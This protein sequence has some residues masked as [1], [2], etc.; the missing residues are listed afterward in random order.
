MSDIRNR[1]LAIGTTPSNTK[2]SVRDRLLSI[3]GESAALSEQQVNNA[4]QKTFSQSGSKP[5]LVDQATKPRY[6]EKELPGVYNNTARKLDR[7]NNR[8]NSVR[9]ELTSRLAEEAA[10]GQPILDPL[11]EKLKGLERQQAALEAQREKEK[12]EA[13][14][15]KQK[16][17]IDATG[18]STLLPD[19]QRLAELENQVKAYQGM[20]SMDG[21]VPEVDQAVSEYLAL[22]QKLKDQYGKDLNNWKAYASRVGNREM[23]EQLKANTTAD[24]KNNWFG[25][26]LARAPINAASGVGFV[27]ANIQKA[28]RWLTGS[29]APIDYNTPAMQLSQMSNAITKG[30]TERIEEDTAGKWGSDTAVG[31][32]YS[33]LYNLGVSMG[34][35]VIGMATGTSLLMAGAAATN[36]MVE[37][38]ERGATDNQALLFGL[39]AGAMEGVMEKLSIDSLFNMKDPKTAK[40]LALNVLKQGGVEA[41][42]EVATNVANTVADAIIMGDKN[43]LTTAINDYIEQGY[44]P[45][46]AEKKAMKDWGNGLVMDAIGGLIS[47]GTFEAVKGGTGYIS[48]RANTSQ[49]QNPVDAAIQNTL[50][51]NMPRS[52]RTKRDPLRI[53]QQGESTSATMKQSQVDAAIQ[54]TLGQNKIA[55]VAEAKEESASV[56]AV[57]AAGIGFDPYSHASNTY[58]A[59]EPGENP[60]RVV[61]VP[62]SMDGETNVMQTVRTIMEADVT[63]DAA[64][65]VLENEIV[66][67]SFS[68]MPITDQ[69]AAGRAESTIKRVGYD[70]ALADWRAEVRAGRVSKDSVAIGETLYNAA[71]SAGDT[72]SAVKIAIDLSTQV[73][74]AAQALQA[75]RMLK[76]M[77]PAAQLY[78]VKQSVDNLQKQLQ[79]QYGDRAP[80]LV[81]DETLAANFL[82]AKTDAER[83]A[84]EEA[85]YKDIA[86]QIP[87][88]FSDKWNAWRYLSMLGNP[89]THIRN[90]IGNA[91]FAPVRGVKN[92]VGGLMEAIAQRAGIIDKSQRTKSVGFNWSKK[93]RDLLKAAKADYINAEGQIQSGD[94]Y[95]SA[96]DIIEKNRRIFDIA[97]LET[98]RRGNSAAL[99]VEDKWFSKGA[100]ASSLAGY[101]NARGYTAEDFTGNGMTEQQKD[102]ARSYAILEAQKATYRDLNALSELVTSMKFKNP[103]NS[104]TKSGELAK[105]AANTVVEGVLPFKKTPANILARAVE[106]SPAGLIGT[107]GKRVLNSSGGALSNSNVSF[108]KRFGDGMKR[109]TGGEYTATEFMDD[110]SAGL[111][112]SGLF[113]LGYFL[114]QSDLLVGGSPEDEDQF[115][116]ENRQPYALEV[117]GTSVTL[118]WLAPEAL[119]VFMG[120]ELCKAI[121]AVNG[122]AFSM[123]TMKSFFRGVTGPLLEMSMLSGL[124][125]ALDAVSYAD[126]KMTAVVANAALGY[127]G[128]AIPILFG[129]IE[130]I[131]GNDAE[132]R[133]TTFT[134]DG[135][136]LDKDT[137]YALGNAMNKV[138]LRDFQQIPYID[139]WGRTEST[140]GVVARAA[141]NLV[142]PAYVSQVAETPV[143]AEIK[144]LEE[145]TGENLTP[146]RAE[147]VLTV[148][149]EKILLTADE[150]VTYATAKGQNDY[151]LRE[152]LLD[153]EE[154]ATLDDATKVKAMG[155][156]EEYAD[157]LARE[158]TGL[159]ADKAEWMAE[160]DGADIGTVTQVLLERA[161]SSRAGSDNY[162]NKYA[163]ISDMLDTG[164]IND[165]LALAIMSDSAVDGYMEYCKKAGVSV[166]EYADVYAYMNKSDSKESTLKYIEKLSISKGKKVA[167]AQSIYGANPTFIPTDSDVPKN[168][169]L[170]MGATDEI[171]NQFSD[172]QKELY[173]S[174]ILDTGIDMG[175]YLDVWTF[176]NSAK[177]DKDA[178]GKTTYSAQNKVIDRIDKL[179]VSNE[180]KRNL[181]LAMG[182]SAK[183]IPYWWK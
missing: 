144:R 69:A 32:V 170:E 86:R 80:D 78:G 172:N 176:K 7:V 111:T 124:Q 150:Y 143:D 162:E 135:Q 182:Y 49:A 105:R 20:V 112:G 51:E 47:G 35:S 85:L 99:D 169:L 103:A 16:A 94:K 113:A 140:G 72:K 4:V 63:P 5:T 181:F 114:A 152:S 1:L 21:N 24:A 108:I 87:A 136:F 139:A 22:Q 70:Q 132:I 18:N 91:A 53:P 10:S 127:L 17:D 125:D 154:Y 153:S 96:T 11:R 159:K 43:Q 179:N 84:A 48:N 3:P 118:D 129:Q 25:M 156:A 110:L 50:Q 166:A 116:L 120:V 126:D 89:R 68:A 19:L 44:S 58:G 12:A 137:Q 100:Y 36:A 160:L 29:D 177:S 128:Q 57:G 145:Q 104:R 42:E 67:G 163:G 138:P 74:S 77:S 173:N 93:R 171:V 107:V 30:A 64:I 73:R 119:P 54:E 134:Q 122:Q 46:E 98:L 34:D 106:Y 27:D 148:D 60:A 155:F 76:K 141:N 123:E 158:E 26:T 165:T 14:E 6:S 40:Q 164:T 167:L 59:I 147:K 37:A 75:V 115:N 117:G 61:D 95:N 168:W 142:N 88:N 183:N 151:T 39:T 66:K 101:L 175:D 157:V 131:I 161:A 23:A 180:D 55:P 2:Q 33:G 56:N 102:D 174:Y 65:P 133:Q 97:A 8:A 149:G 81:I 130:R 146:A 15:Q 52:Q 109:L 79:G 41:T 83:T 90:I 9:N 92:Q 178:N 28:Q 31:N 71:I 13:W 121:E 38:K 62:K 82:N 45:E